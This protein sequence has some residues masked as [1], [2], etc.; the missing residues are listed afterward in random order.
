MA[1]I[2]GEAI[3]FASADKVLFGTDYCNSE[4]QIKYAVE[5][6][7]NFQIPKDLQEGY[8]FAPISDEDRRKIFG[9]NLAKLLEIEPRRRVPGL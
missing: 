1:E 8:G 5:G 7:R 6:F 9:L 2:I 4:I 3:Q